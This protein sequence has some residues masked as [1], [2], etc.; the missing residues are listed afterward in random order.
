MTRQP[1]SV[2]QRAPTH[3]CAAGSVP[4]PHVRP[5]RGQPPAVLTEGQAGDAA[6]L[7]V[8]RRQ[9]VACGRR[10]GHSL[11]VNVYTFKVNCIAFLH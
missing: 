11:G 10:G 4:E 2:T 9:L 8:Q 5:A 6:A 3:L 1:R 7:A